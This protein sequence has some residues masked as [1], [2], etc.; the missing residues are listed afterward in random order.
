M[1]VAQERPVIE[2]AKRAKDLRQAS[3]L[4]TLLAEERLG[5][6]QIAWDDLASR[7]KQWK[8]QARK[9]MKTMRALYPE[10]PELTHTV[11][12]PSTQEFDYYSWICARR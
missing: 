10:M 4:C 1:I 7:G 5:D 2:H 6:L 9:G 8:S 11:V 12:A 3:L